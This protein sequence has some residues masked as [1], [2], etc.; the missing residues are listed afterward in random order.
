MRIADIVVIC[1]ITIFPCWSAENLMKNV[2]DEV[3]GSEPGK[4]VDLG[5]LLPVAFG[6]F[7]YD[8]F[9]DV[10][11]VNKKRDNTHTYLFKQ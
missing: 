1:V 9:T 10:F 11:V 5:D 8:K 4:N 6:D 7:N 2:T 3:F